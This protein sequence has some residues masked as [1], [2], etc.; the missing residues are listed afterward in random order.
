METVAIGAQTG[1]AV[2]EG[3]YFPYLPYSLPRESN[4][5]MPKLDK[6]AFHGIAGQ[7]IKWK[8]PDI[9]ACPNAMLIQFLAAMS[10]LVGRN[11]HFVLSDTRHSVNL[12][13]A[14]V[15]DSG[16]A[17]K[18]TAW[19][20]TKRLLNRIDPSWEDHQLLV[21]I[22][23]GQAII[24]WINDNSQDARGIIYE[25]ELS[26]LLKAANGK[27][28]V[29]SPAMRVIWDG[30]STGNLRS[31]SSRCIN[32]TDN[33]HLAMVAHSTFQDV[34][35]YLSYEDKHN[36]F[37]NRIL[38][39]C[40]D[41]PHIIPMPQPSDAIVESQFVDRLNDLVSHAKTVGQI[42]IHK[43]ALPLW[44]NLVMKESSA[45]QS[46]LDEIKPLLTRG[47]AQMLRLAS[48]YALLDGESFIREVHLEA[49]Y[50]IWQFCEASTK[51][52]FL[53]DG[54][55]FD[56]KKLESALR[57][58][59]KKG[60]TETEIS[61]LLKSRGGAEIRE[62]RERLKSLGLA[63][64]RPQQT[65]GRPTITWYHQQFLPS[66]DTSPETFSAELREKRELREIP[67]HLPSG[68]LSIAE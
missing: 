23:S 63:D 54:L 67:L 53:G 15:G 33:H 24:N 8:S 6:A 34:E 19:S 39:A 44:W 38:W 65:K 26:R 43:D 4:P 25:S 35:K 21:G 18:G 9:E 1:T 10:G 52:I 60:L 5:L 11:P 17:R 14:V 49:A 46:R 20:P 16:E 59:G 32:A 41:V 51:F 2:A 12:F 64:C 36:G 3:T 31:D 45:S 28:S 55:S 62:C 7:F 61:K 57:A 66:A 13:V 47:R 37:A 58:N 56:E 42:E 50:A 40:A 27:D 68:E 29:I 22:A 30:D 48:V